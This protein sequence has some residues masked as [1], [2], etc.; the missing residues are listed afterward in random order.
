MV[1]AAVEVVVVE[2]EGKEE[3]S[4]KCGLACTTTP[5]V[6]GASVIAA[7]YKVDDK[8]DRC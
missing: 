7:T 8:N 2:D 6:P 4:I 5:T 3:D 1:S